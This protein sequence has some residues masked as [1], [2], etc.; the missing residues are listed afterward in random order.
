MYD[1]IPKSDSSK[2]KP[3]FHETEAD[4]LMTRAGS[5]DAPT[6]EEA[7]RQLETIL[8]GLHQIHTEQL[9]D[10]EAGK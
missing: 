1:N 6:Q 4:E 5:A 9:Q 3:L 2:E 10:K 8:D 7:W